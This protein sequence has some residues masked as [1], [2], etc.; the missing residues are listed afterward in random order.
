ML[1]VLK[2]HFNCCNPQQQSGRLPA[3][4]HVAARLEKLRLLQT[5]V[6]T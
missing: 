4:L 6:Q 1:S 3:H 2:A 5:G